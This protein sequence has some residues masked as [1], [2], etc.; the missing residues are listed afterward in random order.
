VPHIYINTTHHDLHTNPDAVRGLRF[1]VD[2]TGKQAE[3][4]MLGLPSMPSEM[5]A[6]REEIRQLGQAMIDA[7]R[8]AGSVFWHPKPKG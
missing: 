3:V 8:D 4:S 7:S 1:T 6:F 2:Y 5:D